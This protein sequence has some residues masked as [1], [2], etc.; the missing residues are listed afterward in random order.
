MILL[1]IVCKHYSDVI[2][3]GMVSRIT[4]VLIVYSTVCSGAD[5]RKY[6]SSASLAFVRGIHRW[7]VNSPYK[8]PVTRKM[9]AFDDVIMCLALSSKSARLLNAGVCH[10]WQNLKVPIPS[11]CCILQHC[12]LCINIQLDTLL[13]KL[14]S[15][16]VTFQTYRTHHRY[17]C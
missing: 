4:G 16:S 5:Q 3:S 1:L 8:G 2:M 7:P 11:C 9:F 14:C 6:Q 13:C 12:F 17:R 15:L 10:W